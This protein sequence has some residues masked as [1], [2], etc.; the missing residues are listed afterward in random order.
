MRYL[1][2]S[3]SVSEKDDLPILRAVHLAG[4]AEPRQVFE[5][6]YPSRWL[7]HRWESFRWRIRRLIEHE[8][9]GKQ[10]VTGLG[11]V[12]SLGPIGELTLQ[13]TEPIIVERNSRSRTANGRNQQWHDCGL[14]G[15]QLALRRAGVVH[16]WMHEVEIRATNDFTTGRYVK[17]Y[18]AI[19][20]FRLER[21]VA[22]AALEYERSP[23]SSREY[24]RICDELEREQR[25]SVFLYL[26]HS[27]QLQT[28]LLHGL[29]RTKRTILI[30]NADEFCTNP[31]A[32]V[33]VDARTGH[34]RTF[35]F[36]FEHRE[37]QAPFEFVL[38][39]D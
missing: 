5:Y 3:I 7:G 9:L 23:K 22:T 16:L 28:F 35:D 37:V 29:R 38:P 15:I 2:G 13:K 32:A 6:M 24:G 8:Y 26:A 30:A 10:R 39:T 21:C 31:R 34:T 19:V 11:D 33:L 12:L 17:D 25:L 36:L 18:D 4:H 20:T 27:Q 1:K 14:F